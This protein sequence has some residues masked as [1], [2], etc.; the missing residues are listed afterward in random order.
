[1]AAKEQSH[2]TNLYH[3]G[4]TDHIFCVGGT[5]RTKNVFGAEYMKQNLLNR[6][7]HGE[8]I[9]IE[10]ISNDSQSNW[11]VAYPIIRAHQWHSIMIISS[12]LHIHRLKRLLFNKPW[13]GLDIYFYPYSYKTAQPQITL[14]EIWRQVHYEWLA[15]LSHYCLPESWYH[16][17]IEK[18]RQ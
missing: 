1:M 16:Y 9:L 10:K 5:R 11:Q 12:P 6:G 13:Q 2:A 14:F 3:Q 15:Y 4:L 8:R 18:D 7:V 17:F